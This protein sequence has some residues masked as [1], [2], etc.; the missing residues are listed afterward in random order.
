MKK[1]LCSLRRAQITERNVLCSFYC[2]ISLSFVVVYWLTRSFIQFHLICSATLSFFL[3]Q[4]LHVMIQKHKRA[5]K[6]KSD[7]GKQFLFIYIYYCERMNAYQVLL[8]RS[9]CKENKFCI[10]CHSRMIG[11]SNRTI[12]S[13][14]ICVLNFSMSALLR[15]DNCCCALWV[16]LSIFYY[17]TNLVSQYPTVIF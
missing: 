9:I 4:H 11:D 1:L 16:D 8:F 2:K 7:V 17:E 10:C 5:A 15:V 14:E 13:S 12:P 3:P 6:K